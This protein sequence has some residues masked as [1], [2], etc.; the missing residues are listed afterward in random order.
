M[1]TS[2]KP[3]D[4]EI[5]E[6]VSEL[7]SSTIVDWGLEVPITPNTQLIQELGLTSMDMIN[8]LAAIDMRFNCRLPYET[9]VRDDKGYRQEISVGEICSFVSQNF[10]VERSAMPTL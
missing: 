5:I 6:A 9:L 8:L 4:T 1:S 2:D 10:G 3:S 7:V